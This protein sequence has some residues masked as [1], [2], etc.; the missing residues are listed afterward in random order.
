MLRDRGYSTAGVV[1]S[2]LLRKETGINQGFNLFDAN[3]PATDDRVAAL[4]RD[5][6]I[7]ADCR[8]LAR[9]ASGSSRAFLFLHLDGPHPPYA[10]AGIFGSAVVLRRRPSQVSTRSSDRLL[11]YLKT[12]QLYDQSTMIL[13]G[14]SRRRAGRSR[15]ERAWPARL[16]RGAA[17]AADHQAAGRR[18][19]GRR[20]Q[21]A[22][23][24]ADLVPTIL[25]LAKAP[26]PGNL[27]GRSLTPLLDRD[28]IIANQLIYSES[29]F[30]LYHFGWGG[31]DQSH[32]RPVSLHPRTER[33]ALRS[34]HRSR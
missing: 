17:G 12:H 19:A 3:L 30:G 25:D 13:R 24:Q 31:A 29:L 11:R 14:V 10:D 26:I 15:R 2:F 18:R 21:I 8:T 6:S 20:V 1:S 7:R 23:Q 4:R 5:P 27:R 16:R 32:R 9:L 33:R 34:R 28:G 22:V